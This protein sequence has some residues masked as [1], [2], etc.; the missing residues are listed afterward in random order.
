MTAAKSPSKSGAA[1]PKSPGRVAGAKSSGAKSV[2]AS[3][4]GGKPAG[5]KSV[6]AKSAGASSTGGESSGAKS[7]AAK[8]AALAEVSATAAAELEEEELH[9]LEQAWVSVEPAT[10]RRVLVAA[11]VAFAARGY[12][13]TSTRDIAIEAGLSPAGVYVHFRSK[14]ELLYRISLLGTERAHGAVRTAAAADADPMA[15]LRAVVG[16]LATRSARHHTTGRV[17]EYELGSLSEPHR[18]QI[19]TLRREIDACVREILAEGVAAGVFDVPDVPAT[20]VALLSLTVD[21][22]RWYRN[23][24]RNTPEEVGAFYADLATRMVRTG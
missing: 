20:A 12:H 11:V 15:R 1:A 2:G 24:G 13:A 16:E 23:G 4:S 3:S 21:I 22:A 18:A 19:S 17:I 14:E 5:T 7:A 9:E 6:G 10:A 8:S